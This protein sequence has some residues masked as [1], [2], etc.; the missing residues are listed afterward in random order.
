MRL[1]DAL[2]ARKIPIY[3]YNDTSKEPQKLYRFSTFSLP[4]PV[5]NGI[6]TVAQEKRMSIAPG[7]RFPNYTP[8]LSVI[9]GLLKVTRLGRICR[10]F[11]GRKID[12]IQIQ[13]SRPFPSVISGCLEVARRNCICRAPVGR[14]Y[15]PVRFH[16]VRHFPFLAFLYR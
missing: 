6:L 13:L 15:D 8:P 12:P 5:I 4:L 7:G 10:V 14:F 1:P 2:R 16:L 3:I 9:N 11:S